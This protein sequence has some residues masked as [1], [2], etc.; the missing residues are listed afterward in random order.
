MYYHIF[1]EDL[2]SVCFF[3]AFPSFQRLPAL[4]NLW[5]LPP[6]FRPATWQSSNLFLTSAC[7]AMSPSLTLTFL[8]PSSRDPC[9]YIRPLWI[10]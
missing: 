6:S 9:D 5:P 3:F 2:E 7:N 4:P 10:V 1:L 8:P